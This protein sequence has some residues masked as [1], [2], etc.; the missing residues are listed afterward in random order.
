MCSRK[1]SGSP[2]QGGVETG[3]NSWP[4]QHTPP[5]RVTCVICS[6]DL[7][8]P[9]GGGKGREQDPHGIAVTVRLRKPARSGEPTPAQAQFTGWPQ[10]NP[11]SASPLRAR[12]IPRGLATL[13]ANM[14]PGALRSGLSSPLATSWAQAG[15]L[16]LGRGTGAPLPGKELPTSSRYWSTE[17]R[18]L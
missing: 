15:H 12:A 5:F 13:S 7:T 17:V 2:R 10:A 4:M 18:I 8:R 9:Q 14:E 6:R 3:K 1:A 16:S 11:L